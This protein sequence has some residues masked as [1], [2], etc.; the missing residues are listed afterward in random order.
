MH[1]MEEL[2][3]ML[4]RELDEI[5][6]KGELSAGSLDAVDKLTHSIKSIETIMAMSDYSNDYRDSYRGSYARED[7]YSR[8]ANRGSYRRG[9]SRNEDLK[10]ELREMQK[11]VQDPESQ[12]MISEWMR[13]LEQ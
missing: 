9:Y 10:N 7:G 4:C 12:R 1:K 13:E 6:K 5:T 3:E 2:K 8:Y 11:S